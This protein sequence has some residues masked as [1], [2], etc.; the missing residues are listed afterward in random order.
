M[1]KPLMERRRRQRINDCLNQLKSML[2]TLTHKQV[3][4]SSA[5]VI[6]SIIIQFTAKLLIRSYEINGIRHSL[7]VNNNFDVVS[8]QSHR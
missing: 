3:A 2:E 5:S 1:N 4:F 8:I 7:A 6:L